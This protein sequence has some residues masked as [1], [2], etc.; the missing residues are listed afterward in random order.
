MICWLNG[1]LVEENDPLIHINDSGFTTG[2]GIFD[3]MLAE[4]GTPAWLE[5]HYE[6]LMHDSQTVIGLIPE[7]NNFEEITTSLLKKNNLTSGYARVRSVVTGGSVPGP[8]A[9]AQKP[10]F[11]IS[12]GSS[13]APD[14]SPLRCAVIQ[15]FPRIAGCVLENCKRIDY[16]RSYAARRKA[17]SIGAT[18]AILTNTD[19][20][21]ACGAT[22]NVFIREGD[23]LIT[24]PLSEGVLAGITRKKILNG[25]F[26]IQVNSAIEEQISPARLKDADAVYLT[27]SFFGLREVKLY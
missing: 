13:P 9:P 23:T 19:G 4:D 2:I 25:D 11:L 24:P 16:S 8:L 21:I 7:I 12:V 3:S 6:R 5:D 1:H 15:D 26:D 14:K 27:N 20:N 22:S 10:T 18:E 17:E